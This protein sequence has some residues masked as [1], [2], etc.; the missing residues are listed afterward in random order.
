MRRNSYPSTSKSAIGTFVCSSNFLCLWG[1]E[2]LGITFT[3]LAA[4]LAVLLCC[5]RCLSQPHVL[6]TSAPFALLLQSVLKR[7]DTL[8]TVRVRAQ[9][10]V[11][12]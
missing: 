10:C 8:Y 1:L 5:L 9:D 6:P 7:L 4:K 2:G 11:V 12:P 3:A